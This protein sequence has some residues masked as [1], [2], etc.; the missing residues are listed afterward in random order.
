MIRE[1]LLYIGADL[2]KESHTCVLVNC[3]NECDLSMQRA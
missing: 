3:W 1:K 2:H